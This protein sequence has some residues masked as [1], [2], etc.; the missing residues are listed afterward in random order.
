ME[1]NLSNLLDK[2]N[3]YNTELYISQKDNVP[4]KGIKLLEKNQSC[5]ESDYLYVGK[6]LNLPRILPEGILINILCVTSSALPSK[7]KK[8]PTLN[9][10]ILNTNTDIVTVFNELQEII[11][12]HQEFVMNSAKLLSSLVSGKGIEHIVDTGC[13]LL[14]NP[15][16]ILDLSFKLIA[17]SKNIKVD[18][19]I[20]IELLTKGYCSYEFVSMSSAKKFIEVVHKSNSPIFMSKDKFRIPRIISNIKIDNK[21]VGYLTALECERP[22]TR[23]DID[24][25]FLLCKV[26]SSEME[27]SKFVQNNKGLSYEHFLVNLLQGEKMDN[28]TIE[29]RL[30]FLD[31][32]FKNNLYVLV[33][34]VPKNSFVNIS[35]NRL[36]DTIEYIL[37]DSK[38]IIYNDYIVVLISRNNKISYHESSLVK[39]RAFLKKNNIYGGLSRCFHNLSDIKFYYDQSVKA[40]ELGARSKINKFLFCYEDAAVQHLLEICSSESDLK[41]FCHA[42]IFTL[43]EY[44][45]MNNTN[46]TESLYIYLMN[47]KSQL[48]TADMLNVCRSTLA[49]RIEKIQKIMDIDLS[50]AIITFRLILSFIIL[51]YVDDSKL[52]DKI[53]LNKK[54]NSNGDVSNE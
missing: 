3:H 6:N 46:Y 4:I 2:I 32:H 41:N 43:M 47:E 5:F 45:S 1:I 42:S 26:F 36:R 37:V 16:C 40:I 31:L 25:I 30:K 23:N 19:P 38:S 7:Y 54:L 12:N 27:K 24:L 49:H 28:K 33:V 44:D 14:G 51:E 18:D 11:I 15:L 53:L 20:W 13:E 17:A 10:I 39:L 21:I 35:L 48:E 52:I 8:N 22:F 50:D 9:L 29:E 34:S